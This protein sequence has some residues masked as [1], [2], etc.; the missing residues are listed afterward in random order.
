[1][2]FFLK[3]LQKCIHS[4]KIIYPSDPFETYD[5][6]CE[7]NEYSSIYSYIYSIIYEIYFITKNSAIKNMYLVFML[8]DE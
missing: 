5:T 8:C 7:N 6:I 3:L 2:N 4:K 1:M